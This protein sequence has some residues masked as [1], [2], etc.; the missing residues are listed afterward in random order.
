MTSSRDA[1]GPGPSGHATEWA[2]ADTQVEA[3][4]VD[5]ILTGDPPR[6]VVRL[7]AGAGC[8]ACE[9]RAFCVSEDA[10]GERRRLVARADLPLPR[11]GDAVRVAVRGG[12]LLSAGLWAY[13]LPLLGLCVGTLGG[14]A[15]LVGAPHRELAATAAGLIGA[16]VPLGVLWRRSRSGP[17]ERWLDA[18][19]IDVTRHDR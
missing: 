7:V 13:G 8:E 2:G 12:R 15:L 1:A 4:V 11:P 9:A 16:A 18:R 17:P 3:G 19:V 6:V 14:W 10:D 5:A